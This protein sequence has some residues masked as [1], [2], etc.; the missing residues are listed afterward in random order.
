MCT[1]KVFI[2]STSCR[3]KGNHHSLFGTFHFFSGCGSGAF[4]APPSLLMSKVRANFC[5]H[6]FLFTKFKNRFFCRFNCVQS[7]Q[8]FLQCKTNCLFLTIAV[9]IR[10]AFQSFFCGRTALCVDI[11][12]EFVC[13]Q[14]KTNF[15]FNSFV[16]STFRSDKK[17]FI[18][19]FHS[20]KQINAINFTQISIC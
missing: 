3:T 4:F 5:T 18:R 13:N 1:T 19:W 9:N 7:G 10:N 12:I 17:M 11:Q 16:M 6:M 14:M 2:Y 8:F 15:R 20:C